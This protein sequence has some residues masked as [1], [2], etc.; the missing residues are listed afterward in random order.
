MP[1][2]HACNEDDANVIYENTKTG[3]ASVDFAAVKEA[4][5]DNLECLGLSPVD[6]GGLYD[7][8]T[9]AYFEGAEPMVATAASGSDA[10]TGETGDEVGSTGTSSAHGQ[11]A[12]IGVG[13]LMI[14]SLVF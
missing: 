13:I 3:A 12:T 2:V 8:D 4:F 10:A 14:V 1:L 9:N 6:I 5:Q 11:A 7:P